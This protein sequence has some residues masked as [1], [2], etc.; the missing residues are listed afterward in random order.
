[1][2]VASLD[3]LQRLLAK[4]PGVGEKT[5]LRYILRLLENDGALAHD[6]AEELATL[7]NRIGSC[8]RCGHLAERREALPLL[9]AVCTD[10]RRDP[11]ILCV[12]ARVPDVLA[13][14]RAGAYR[15]RYH[16]LGR[17]L[18]PLDGIGPDELGLD[19]LLR[20]A[21]ED[22]VREVVIATPPTVG[23]MVQVV[24]NTS[25]ASVVGLVELVRAGQLVNNSLIAPLTVYTIIAS[26]Y[27]ALCFPLSWW[28]R[29]LEYKL[30][31][32]RAQVET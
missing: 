3:R 30:T 5:A 12:V 4:L 15:G 7:P 9:C 21:R 1:M 28:S 11:S 26:F 20:R 32:R 31:V 14:E 16:V 10:E 27:F 19:R 13:L 24:K 25:L 8:E 17:L 23:F 6:L 2:R 18:S 29:K 22:G